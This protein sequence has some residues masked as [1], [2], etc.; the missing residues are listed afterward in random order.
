MLKT[1]SD[2]VYGLGYQPTSTTSARLLFTFSVRAGYITDS[3]FASNI[4]FIL[5]S[6]RAI[7]DKVDSRLSD[8]LK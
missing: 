2:G 4:E 3:S 8:I 7:F 1:L 6:G 5:R